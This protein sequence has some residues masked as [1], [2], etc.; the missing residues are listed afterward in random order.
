MSASQIIDI[1][2]IECTGRVIFG[3]T[4]SLLDMQNDEKISYQIVGEDEANVKIGKISYSSPLARSLIGKEE[5]ETAKFESPSGAKE[6][7]ILKVSH[8]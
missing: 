8:I 2:K 6:Y 4:I 3:S 1:T 7:E 5:G